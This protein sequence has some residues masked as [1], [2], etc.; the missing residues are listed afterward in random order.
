MQIAMCTGKR[1]SATIFSKDGNVIALGM[2]FIHQDRPSAAFFPRN[3]NH[4][5]GLDLKLIASLQLQS[6]EPVAV[7][8]T[9]KCN[10]CELAHLSMWVKQ[11]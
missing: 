10:D 9:E 4:L 3:K 2:G 7:Y 8:G 6:C 1:V 11:P 5:R